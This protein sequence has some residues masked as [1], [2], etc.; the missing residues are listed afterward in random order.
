M[1]GE[2]APMHVGQFVLAETLGMAPLERYAVVPTL[3]SLVSSRLHATRWC[4]EEH[5]T[6]I[7]VASF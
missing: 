5:E 6:L 3:A 2:Q 1:E 4:G 7:F